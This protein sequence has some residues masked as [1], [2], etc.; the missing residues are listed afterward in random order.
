MN[1][2]RYA[3][4]AQA[5]IVTNDLFRDHLANLQTLGEWYR[6]VLTVA[7]QRRIVCKSTGPDVS[8]RDETSTLLPPFIAGGPG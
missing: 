8:H 6:F 4:G 5:H 2:C 3:V 7:D 1:D